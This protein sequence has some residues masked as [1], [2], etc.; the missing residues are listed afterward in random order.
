MSI[1]RLMPQSVIF[2]DIHG[3]A[4]ATVDLASLSGEI[5]PPKVTITGTTESTG[6]ND[7]V[8]ICK[9]GA[10][11]DKKAYFLTNAYLGPTK[12]LMAAPMI[13]ANYMTLTGPFV[14]TQIITRVV[15]FGPMIFY[16][17]PELSLAGAA[18]TIATT[19]ANFMG[20][21][22]RPTHDQVCGNVALISMGGISPG[23]ATVTTA[24]ALI[25]D[26]IDSTG[27]GGIGNPAGWQACCLSWM[28]NT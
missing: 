21:A 17:L 22:D 12:T 16:Y 23:K 1:V 4:A 27:F 9:G 15:I 3:K 19:S 6:T 25:I 14:E 13:Y 11:I 28:L 8:L 5:K 10:E 26:Q 18:A 7:G 24:G 2:E 20:A